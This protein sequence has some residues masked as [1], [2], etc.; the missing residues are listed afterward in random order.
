MG[1]LRAYNTVQLFNTLC[2]DLETFYQ[3]KLAFVIYNRVRNTRSRLRVK[4]EKLKPLVAKKL[5]ADVDYL[6]QVTNTEKKT[7][8]VVDS[9]LEICSCKVGMCGAPCKH[10]LQVVK[11]FHI[12]HQQFLPTCDPQMKMILYYIMTGNTTAPPGLFKTLRGGPNEDLH[13][14]T[15]IHQLNEDVHHDYV[16]PRECGNLDLE[17]TS[18]EVCM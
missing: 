11:T 5:F 16:E 7:E 3:R 18:L 17:A 9:H 14:L 4:P 13:Q 8:Y 12:S 10:Q 1:R 15:D 6:F 2:K